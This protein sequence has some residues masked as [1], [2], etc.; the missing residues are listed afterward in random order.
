MKKYDKVVT[1]VLERRKKHITSIKELAE[2]VIEK[3]LNNFESPRVTLVSISYYV[4]GEVIV[5]S[6][7]SDMEEE[8]FS[9]ESYSDLVYEKIKQILTLESENENSELSKKFNFTI[10]ELE[11]VDSIIIELK[12]IA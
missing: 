10:P 7:E 5:I 11:S 4:K 9:Y 6:A 12:P 2:T 3:A 8:S 1:E